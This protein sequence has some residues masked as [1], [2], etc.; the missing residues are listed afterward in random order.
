MGAIAAGKL[1]DLG[2]PSVF[3]SFLNAYLQPRRGHISVEN[4]LSSA[5]VLTDQVFQGTVLGPPLWNAFFSDVTAA[6][7]TGNQRAQVFADDLKVENSYPETLSDTFVVN[8][9][10]AAQRRAH[11]WGQRNRVAFDPNKEHFHIIH[12]L[13][14]NNA[15]FRML[16]TILDSKLSMKPCIDYVL[17]VVRPNF[18]ALIKMKHNFDIKGMISQFKSHIW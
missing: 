15:E 3:L 7:A 5:I 16:G 11:L 13:Y 4:W 18:K 17:S 14:G 9:L 12:P 10:C 8:N 1:A 2:V 6:I